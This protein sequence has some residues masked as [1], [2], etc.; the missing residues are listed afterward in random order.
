MAQ[1]HDFSTGTSTGVTVGSSST[2]ILPATSGRA[3]A[4]LVNDSSEEVYLS[5]G[6]AAEMNKGI[7]LNRRGGV[8]SIGGSKP[9]RGVINGICSSG[10][11][12]VCV[13]EA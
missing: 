5:L 9:F 2:Q 7:R 4:I 10:G 11:K 3:Y 6:S 1:E 8:F 13:M 12:N